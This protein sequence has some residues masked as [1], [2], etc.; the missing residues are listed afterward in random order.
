M[1]KFEIKGYNSYSGCDIIVTA[2]MN[3]INNTTGEIHEKVYTLGSIQTLSVSTHQDKRPVRV[4]GSANAKDYTLG[5][6]TVAGSLVFA[7]FDQHFATEMFDDLQAVTGKSFIMPDELPGLDITITFANE[8]GKTSRMA[9][10]GVRIINEGQVMSINDLYTENTYQFVALSMEP[11]KKGIKAGNAQSDKKK[12]YITQSVAVHQKGPSNQGEEIFNMNVSNNTTDSEK[13]RLAVD[14]EPPQGDEKEGIAV[15]TLSPQ[16]VAGSIAISINQSNNVLKE[17]PVTRKEKKQY[18]NL[19]IGEYSAW[20]HNNGKTLSN[21]VVFS[22]NKDAGILSRNDDAPIIENVTNS[23]IDVYSNNATHTQCV[24]MDKSTGKEFVADIKKRR[25]HFKDLNSNYDYLIYTKREENKS[26]PVNVKTLS[27]ENA[28]LNGYKE[29]VSNN[30]NLLHDDFD[31]YKEILDKLTDDKFIHTLSEMKGN[32]AK[33]LMMM[34][35]KYNNEFIKSINTETALNSAEKKIE[36]I[37]GNTFFFPNGAA[38]A[39]IFRNKDGKNYFESSIPYPTEDTYDGKANTL[40][41]V[42]G[43]NADNVKTPK[44]TFFSF[45]DNDKGFLKD[46]YNKTNALEKYDL[47]SITNSKLSEKALKCLSSKE[48][49][50]QDVK[51]L[52]APSA[53]LDYNTLDLIANVDYVS[54]LG[55]KDTIYYLCLSKLEESLDTTPFRKIKFTDKDRVIVLNKYLTAVNKKDIFSMWI[56]NSSYNVISEVGFVSMS[57]DSRDANEYIKQTSCEKYAKGVETSVNKKGCMSDEVSI[58]TS[59]STVAD[60]D[61]HVKLAQTLLSTKGE[62]AFHYIYNLYEEVFKEKYINGERFKKA[63]YN[64]KNKTV[65]F[66]GATDASIVQVKISKTKTNTVCGTGK[67]SAVFDDNYDINIF[68]MVG[69][70][71]VVKSGFVMLSR[72]ENKYYNLTMEVV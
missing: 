4:I 17:V 22:I 32:K 20:Y 64:R 30:R 18:A 61:A 28:L 26:R 9:L 72:T 14:V 70:D 69:N 36:N 31:S 42:E 59:D 16:Q 50:Q 48:H 15:F 56:E 65:T 37:F 12:L 53:Q 8:Y 45:S 62:D 40:Y 54:E 6:R 47:P 63:V 19:E 44:Y 5:Q 52:K 25:S 27:E 21:V 71:P 29:Y 7:V 13:I 68:Y 43:V 49:K 10:Y 2:R 34:A 1:A 38:K 51:L 11:L 55:Q 41:D 60:K 3:L 24:C 46:R 58:V 33:E 35:V 23:T 39:N 67:N 66:E 57:Q